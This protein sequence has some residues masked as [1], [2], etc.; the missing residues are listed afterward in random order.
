MHGDAGQTH[1]LIFIRGDFPSGVNN[2]FFW[3]GVAGG[4]EEFRKTSLSMHKRMSKAM[5][6]RNSFQRS[7]RYLHHVP[8]TERQ[9]EQEAVALSLFQFSQVS[10]FP[11]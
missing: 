3:G 1:W 10:H 4:M 6:A 5:G 8:N 9:E 11:N 7:T 2:C